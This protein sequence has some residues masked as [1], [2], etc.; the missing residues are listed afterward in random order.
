MEM[1]VA[2]NTA[3]LTLSLNKSERRF[4]KRGMAVLK[5]ASESCRVFEAEMVI[6]KGSGVDGTTIRNKYQTVVHILNVRQTATI[7]HIQLVQESVVDH[8]TSSESN[9]VIRPGNRAKIRFRFLKR[10]VST[11]YH[12]FGKFS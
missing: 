12:T 6:I 1:A 11:M 2:G 10:K 5:Q 3:C 9:V 4:L 8:S 7:E